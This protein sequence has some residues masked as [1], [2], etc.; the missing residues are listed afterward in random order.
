MQM[1]CEKFTYLFSQLHPKSK[2][3]ERL[4][5]GQ[6]AI[7]HNPSRRQETD[8]KATMISAPAIMQQAPAAT[9]NTDLK[10]ILSRALEM[11]SDAP[12]PTG[13]TDAPS[14]GAKVE[15]STTLVPGPSSSSNV[16]SLADTKVGAGTVAAT[17][18]NINSNSSVTTLT[19]RR[20]GRSRKP[21][22]KAVENKANAAALAAAGLLGHGDEYDPAA[23]RVA[24]ISRESST[25]SLIAPSSPT[26]SSSAVTG[27]GAS[28]SPTASP[29]GGKKSWKKPAGKPKRPLSAYNIFFKEERARLVAEINGAAA[30]EA[31]RQQSE[32]ARSHRKTHGMGF[33][34]LAQNIAGKWKTLDNASRRPYEQK[35]AVDKA[36]YVREVAAWKNSLQESAEQG[37][38]AEYSAA[39]ATPRAQQ[40]T[41]SSSEDETPRRR[42]KKRKSPGKKA[43]TPKRKQPKSTKKQRSRATSS[44][45]APN[46]AA[47]HHQLFHVHHEQQ[48]NYHPN[49][50]S[51]GTATTVKDIAM[52]EPTAV[53]SASASAPAA[54]QG[55][56]STHAPQQWDG[57][58]QMML[59]VGGVPTS[60][61]GQAGL[62]DD[63]DLHDIL[64]LEF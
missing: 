32:A 28:A 18:T 10:G 63:G 53:E 23:A 24:V 57:L 5:A 14:T 48:M 42:S 16:S 25:L 27:A 21:S 1:A 62:V 26:A 40:V 6:C 46:A 37:H 12:T 34:G 49:Q 2:I 36:R 58:D 3:L 38:A 17:P 43:T 59:G 8:R 51:T 60:L 50:H 39:P 29:K 4:W 41:D 44:T 55:Y 45:S 31:E 35:A 54:A 47:N 33:A 11:T 13:G 20:S 56:A 52:F 19:T 7:H 15:T 64:S 61:A 22:S 9:D 30:E